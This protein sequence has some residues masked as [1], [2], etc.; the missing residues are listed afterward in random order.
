MTES[1]FG[2]DIPLERVAAGSDIT[3][4]ESAPLHFCMA[5]FQHAIHMG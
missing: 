3:M 1:G 4:P 2:H 5:L